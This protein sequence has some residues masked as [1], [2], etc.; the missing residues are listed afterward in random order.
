MKLKFALI[1]SVCALSSG[2]ILLP[3]HAAAKVASG[4]VA[5]SREALLSQLSQ[6]QDK[7]KTLEA[8]N[9][10]LRETIDALRSLAYGPADPSSDSEASGGKKHVIQEGET[11]SQ[12][13]SQHGITREALMEVNGITENQ[14]I[15][16]GD[17]LLVPAA[18][19]APQAELVLA[20][21]PPVKPGQ[22]P[23]PAPAPT[24]TPVSAPTP[25]PTPERSPAPAPEKTTTIAWTQP[26]NGESQAD[27]A[28]KQAVPEPKQPAITPPKP[29]SESS[30]RPD[31]LATTTP[32]PKPEIVK[33]SAPAATPAPVPAPTPALKKESPET[34]TPAP[35]VA[36]SSTTEPEDAKKGFTYYTI[37][38][39]DNLGK[40]AKKHGISI[41][42][43]M[44]FNGIK[45]PDKISGG[46]QLK[47]PSKEKAESLSKVRP[48]STLAVAS[49]NGKPLPGDAYGIYTVQTGDTLYDLARDFFTTEKE[50]Q[51]L[52]K[53]G[54]KT[55]IVPGQDLIVPMAE[56]SKRGDLVTST[57]G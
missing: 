9:A 20:E 56:Y 17:E 3:G 51:Q 18:P 35:Q 33:I 23:T 45:N 40:I 24:P 21:A 54:D 11:V 50:I 37:K 57:E 2:G 29:N 31:A 39:G 30:A 16:V 10:K 22:T 42:A 1:F 5:S 28:P 49:A 47:I 53:M 14:Q 25:A 38:F 19:E 46:Q 44:S 43:L 15:Y 13:A 52:N 12:I 26:E 55:N 6:L 27:S 7:V 48:S 4:E 34:S 41:G 36:E 32:A 8:E